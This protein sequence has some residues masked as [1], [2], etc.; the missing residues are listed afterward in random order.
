MSVRERKGAAH[1]GKTG[2]DP[3]KKEAMELNIPCTGHTHMETVGRNQGGIKEKQSAVK[4]VLC[5]HWQKGALT[6]CSSK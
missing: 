6:Q 4:Q 1:G 2:R 3:V 5:E